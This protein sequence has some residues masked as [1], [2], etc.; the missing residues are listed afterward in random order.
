MLDTAEARPSFDAYLSDAQKADVLGDCYQL[1]LILAETEAQ[2]S[3]SRK[4]GERDAVP[5]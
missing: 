4:P 3:S 2:S 1:L 5:A